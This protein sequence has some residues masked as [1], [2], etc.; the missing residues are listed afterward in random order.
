MALPNLYSRRKRLAEKQGDDVY[1]Y[2]KM[3]L[4]LRNQILFIIEGWDKK[5]SGFERYAPVSTTIV[6]MMREQLGENRLSSDYASDKVDELYQWFRMCVRVD[7]LL[8][9]I[10][11]AVR[12]ADHWHNRN[13]GDQETSYG[14]RLAQLNARMLE[15]GF[16]FQ[17]ENGQA[18][19]ISSTFVHKEV[20]IPALGLLSSPDYKSA[21]DEFRQAYAEFNLGNFDD[22]IHDCCNAFES[23]L[24][25]ILTTKG[26]AFNANDPAS[27][28]L[29][30]AFDNA[31]IPSYMQN[32][33]TG[34]RTILE[35]GVPTVR[36]KDGGHGAGVNPR[37]IPK[38]IAAFQLHQTAAAIVLLVEAAE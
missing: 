1:H 26:W 20:T 5:Y 4:K 3:S 31:L 25:I 34:L 9:A 6:N 17:I 30:V 22:C 38:H 11:I 13:F 37:N 18:I 33:F 15:D 24:K 14:M 12:V 10:E 29:A 27:K 36:N 2:D 32:E 8:D 21:E 35:S 7:D 28:L 19:Q 23:V 16:G